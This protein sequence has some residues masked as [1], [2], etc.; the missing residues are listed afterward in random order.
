[1]KKISELVK[2]KEYLASVYNT[3]PIVTEINSMDVKLRAINQD[4][5]IAEVKSDIND[6][7]DDFNTL[8][9]KLRFNKDRYQAIVDSID[10]QIQVESAK[11]LS[12]NY[13]LELRVESEAIGNIRKVRVLDIRPSLEEEIL[14]RIRINTNWKYPALEIGCRDGEWTQHLIAADPLYITDH[15]RDFLESAVK[16]FP[17]EYQ[18]RVRPYLTRDADLSMLPQGQMGFV[19]C[20]NFLNYRS[21]DTVK[22]YLKSVKEVLRPGGVFMFSYN[23][24]DMYECAG[25]AEGF[26]MS[27]IPKRYLVPMCESLGF[28]VVHAREIRG[29]GTAVSWIELKKHGELNTSKANQVLGEIKRIET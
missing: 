25:Y 18:R 24:G 9:N 1:M 10:Q 27:Y 22:E 28:E 11:F 15:Y 20:W 16:D 13:S 26:W 12:E 3:E 8:H 2:I 23:N 7:I 14:N 4:I 6:L 5:D 21:L 17:E 29:E 19:F